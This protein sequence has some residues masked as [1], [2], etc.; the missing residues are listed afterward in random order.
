[1]LHTFKFEANQVY[2]ASSRIS[3]AKQRNPVSENKNKAKIKKAVDYKVSA[4]LNYSYTAK[5][6]TESM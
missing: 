1:M 2:R 6:A 4:V 3:R 5:V